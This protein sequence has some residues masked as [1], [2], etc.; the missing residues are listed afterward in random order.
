MTN[1]PNQISEGKWLFILKKQMKN[2][3]IKRKKQKHCDKHFY[4]QNSN[5]ES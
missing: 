2:E 5:H 3:T 4:L 1:H